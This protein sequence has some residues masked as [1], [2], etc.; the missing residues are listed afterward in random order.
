MEVYAWRMQN[1]FMDMEL[2]KKDGPKLSRR[3]KFQKESFE[4]IRSRRRGNTYHY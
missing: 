2:L 3:S 1:D 4:L